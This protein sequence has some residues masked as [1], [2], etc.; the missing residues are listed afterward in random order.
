MFKRII[1]LIPLRPSGLFLLASSVA[2]LFWT[3]T[4]SQDHVVRVF[5]LGTVLLVFV[6]VLQVAAVAFVCRWAIGALS[7]EA[8]PLK[9]SC[10]API[11]TG[12]NVPVPYWLGVHLDWT[13]PVPS[14]VCLIGRAEEVTFGR[15]G[16]AKSITRNIEVSDFFGFASFAFAITQAREIEISPALKEPTT[17]WRS[18]AA[19]SSGDE[20][21]AQG[22]PEGDMFDIGQ[23]RHGDSMKNILWKL[24]ARRGGARVYVRRPEG[25]QNQR[26][27][28]YFLAGPGDDEVA[29]LADYLLREVIIG[30]CDLFRCSTDLDEDATGPESAHQRL[31]ASGSARKCDATSFEVFQNEVGRQ[32]VAC[33]VF[34]PP[35][36][37]DAELRVFPDS[38]VPVSFVTTREGPASDIVR[39]CDHDVSVIAMPAPGSKVKGELG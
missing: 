26:V 36:V 33:V 23:Y 32:K 3:Y 28:Y 12:F 17:N 19:A 30:P 5:A 8:L 38:H 24:T 21:S 1:P 4:S 9:A 15:R 27:A 11:E 34:V 16:S 20:W 7:G 35:N 37:T 10:G 13:A 39:K 18:P 6:S 31:M 22:K 14:T 29:E 2:L 25:V